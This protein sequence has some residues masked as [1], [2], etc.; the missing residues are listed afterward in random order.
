MPKLLH[1]ERFGRMRW[2]VAGLALILVAIAPDTMPNGYWSAALITLG[3][4]IFA[5]GFVVE[6]DRQYLLDANEHVLIERRS[7]LLRSLERRIAGAQ[8][9]RLAGIHVVSVHS[10]PGDSE[11]SG[12]SVFQLCAMLI[13]GERIALS[14]TNAPNGAPPK[15]PASITEGAVRD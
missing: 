12:P 3:L 6:V 11:T 10:E 5:L 2:F 13:S 1:R 7:S 14:S 15:Y 8:I 4:A 9:A